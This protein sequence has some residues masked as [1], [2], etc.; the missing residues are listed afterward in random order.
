MLAHALVAVLTIHDH[1]TRP[2]PAGLINFT[3]AESCCLLCSVLTTARESTSVLAWSRGNESSGTAPGSAFTPA[4][5]TT[6]RHDQAIYGFG[7]REYE[8]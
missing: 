6:S 7:T 5:T 8:P 3:C 1:A 4:A 2:A